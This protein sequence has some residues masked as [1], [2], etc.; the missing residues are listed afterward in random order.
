MPV[1]SRSRRSSE[2]IQSR[3]SRAA[4]LRSRELRVPVLADQAALAQRERRL[5]LER[6]V[7]ELVQRGRRGDVLG[8]GRRGAARPRR[9]EVLP[10]LG[11]A[12]RGSRAARRGP[13]RGPAPRAARLGEAL[14]IAHAAQAPAAGR[15]AARDSARERRRPPGARGS[16][17]GRGAGAGA[18]GAGAA[19]PSACASGRA[20]RRASPGSSAP[21]A[22]LEQLERGDGGRIEQHRVAGHQPLEPREVAE[23]L[24]L[25]LRAGTRARPPPPGG[26]RVMSPTPRRRARGREAG[27]RASRGR[28]AARTTTAPRS[29]PGAPS[30]ARRPRQ[31]R[32]RLARHQDL[33]GPAQQRGLEQRRARRRPASPTQKSPVETSTSAT[34][35]PARRRSRASGEQEVVRGA[36][37]DTGCR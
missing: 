23:R 17:R 21:A 9:A 6:L 15:R 3:A 7:E 31:G 4:R 14:E 37:E 36:V 30:A 10:E 11:Q 13:A 28:A 32:R 27:R 16:P 20:R 19:R 5:V 18:T 33:G 25:G 1:R 2:A 22:R 12:P 26:P 34:P 29:S 24:A 35:R 8:R